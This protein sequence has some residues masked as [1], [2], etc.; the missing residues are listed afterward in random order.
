MKNSGL[1]IQLN[2]TV[3]SNKHFTYSV[4]FAGATNDNKFVSFSNA[5]YRGRNYT[6]E[7]YLPSPGSPGS[8]QRLQEGKRIG[9]FFMLRSAGVDAT[10][11]LLVFDKDGKE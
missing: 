8:A 9:G 6:D 10:G 2:G 5:T 7:V 11:R 3:I 1:E 4:S